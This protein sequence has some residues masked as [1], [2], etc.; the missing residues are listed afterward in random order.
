MREIISSLDIGSTKIKL[1]VAEIIDNRLNVLC[2]I[3]EESRGVK[4]GSIVE[5]AETEYA[6]KKILKRAE[7]VLG[8]KVTK[9]IVSVA[10]DNA[11][12]KIGEATVTITS[13]DQE[14]QPSDVVRA[15]QASVKDKVDKNMELVTVIPI[16]FKVDEQ[17][18]RMPARMQ[19][20]KL[21]VKSVVVSV[22]KKDVYLAA[23]T[24]EKCGVEVIDIM[25]PS[26]GSAYAHKN[27][28]TDTLTGIVIDVGGETTKVAVFNK[29]IIINNLVIPYG[30]KQVDNDI[31]FIYKLN[32]E[33]SIKIKENFALANKKNAST[34]E[35][36][37]LINSLG[38]NI[39]INQY[40]VSEV[41]MS[42]LHEMLNVAKNEI[43]YLTKKEI[44][45]II[46]TGGL[47]EIKDFSLE[48]E[49]V[50]GKSAQVGK[51]NIVGVRDNKYASAIGMIRYYDSK[52]KLREK[53]YSIFN[54]DELDI[55]SGNSGKK[56]SGDSVFGKVFGIFFDN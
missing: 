46:I 38:E 16:M 42:R 13:E 24:L 45:Y 28:T 15:L 37:Y 14:I 32:E 40:E 1:V 21:S 31:A 9:T 17:K 43:N 48:V 36:E 41:V 53:D 12:F 8:I 10:E 39:S 44:S 3:D 51:I 5:P 52:L 18:T 55:L 54:Q 29:G 23:K 35:N 2:A 49:S 26:I 50:F 20:S 30:G 34:K 47:T 6:I 4:K 56:N 33:Q 7:E 27:E 11:A 19:G 22:P 25:I